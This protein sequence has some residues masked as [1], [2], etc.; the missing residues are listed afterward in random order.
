MSTREFYKK[1]ETWKVKEARSP[2]FMVITLLSDVP[3]KVRVQ[4]DH[5]YGSKPH[6]EDDVMF[7]AEI[8]SGK[9]GYISIEYTLSQKV[10]GKGTAGTRETFRRTLTRFLKK[11]S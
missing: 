7:D 8:V 10:L 9:K 1:G 3:K 11:V 5:I 4:K 6:P 2:G